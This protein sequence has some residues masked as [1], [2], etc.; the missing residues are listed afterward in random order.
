VGRSGDYLYWNGA[1]WV[2]SDGTYNQANDAV[3]FNLNCGTINVLGEKYGQFKVLFPDNNTQSAVDT[4]TVNVTA[5]NGY[6]T[7]NPTL[8]CNS[9]FRT[10]GLE[11][12]SIVSIITG[13]D[14]IKFILSKDGIDYYHNGVDWAASDG[15]YAQSNT[16]AEIHA[17]R[18]TF[19]TENILVKVKVF[20]HSDTGLTRPILS[21][22]TMTY[23]FAGGAGDT[24]ETCLVWA[25]QLDA[26]GNPSLETLTVETNKNIIK[27]KNSTIIKHER[28]T[29]TP[30]KTGYW[31]AELIETVNMESGSKYMFKFANGDPHVKSVPNEAKKNFWDLT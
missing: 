8:E 28:V 22:I 5:N 12:F 19:T 29:I 2:V 9:T 10:E 31:E 6:L 20:F 27:Y 25:N 7:T 13:S 30:D 24:I 17:N 4:L 14:N 1:A 18:A 15:T 21:S 3:T 11:G 23:D 26:F 16:A